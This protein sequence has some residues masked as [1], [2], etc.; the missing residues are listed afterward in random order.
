VSIFRKN[1]APIL[2]LLFL[3]LFTAA[4]S[5]AADAPDAT[6]Q[7]L[8]E[9]V[10]LTATSS[11]SGAFDS[12]ANL[13]TAE[14][15]ATEVSRS[16]IATQ[17]AQAALS[18]ADRAA[19][20]TAFAPFTADLPNYGVDPSQGRPG[21]IHPPLEINI[22]GF[23]TYD[24]GNRFIGTVAA[25]FVVSADITW[26]TRFGTSGCG[27]VLRSDGNEEGF[28]QHLVIATRAALGHI[29][30]STMAN[31]E[32]VNGYDM[33]AYGLDP[34]FDWHNDTTN[35]LTVVGVDN[36]FT[37]Y[38]NGT[39]VGE[40]IPEGPP[41]LPAIPS[42]PTEPQPEANSQQR[43]SYNEAVEEYN[44]AVARIRAEHREREAAYAENEARYDRGLIAMVALN[45]SGY[46]NCRFDNAWLWLMD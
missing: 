39:I 26:D 25:D 23:H 42:A 9:S 12:V 1:I 20:A 5:P 38:T 29:I 15:N 34:E 10:A 7:A 13:Q 27:F 40:I 14:A 19:T 45:E 32:V 37:I 18:E 36:K 16:L 41:Q 28:N 35:R 2:C 3:G 24:Y 43:A 17:T 22:E 44:A 4:C 30:F 33:Y 8:S 6:V 11:A 21:W 46:T 31:G